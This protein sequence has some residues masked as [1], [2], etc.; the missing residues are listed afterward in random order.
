[1]MQ[2]RNNL[3]SIKK[4]NIR[5]TDKVARKDYY[6]Q[7][8]NSY[9]FIAPILILFGIFVVFPIVFN[10][11]VSFFKWSGVGE[12]KFSGL[13]NYIR[14]LIEDS[15]VRLVLRNAFLYIIISGSVNISVGLVVAYLLNMK[16]KFTT[17]YRVIIFMPAVIPG[18]VLAT[19]FGSILQADKGIVNVLL[20]KIGFEFTPNWFGDPKLVFFTI[21]II[22]CFIYMGYGMVIYLGGMQNISSE[23]IEAAKIDGAGTFRIF[24]N[25]V[26][27][28]LR[29]GHIIMITLTVTGAFRLFD[30]VWILTKG[31]PAGYSEVPA[32]FIYR[33]AMLEN[34]MGYAG[35]IGVMIFIISIFLIIFLQ[36]IFRKVWKY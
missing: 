30:L 19:I 24:F 28:L 22:S 7:K 34:Q 1:M 35:V 8:L 27:P 32:S 21:I 20:R 3:D 16:I 29:S 5:A 6:G 12:L 2:L 18:V 11:V 13:A 4:K 9:L 25:I 33:A 23:I 14:F 10:I 31:G 15:R 26:V 17:I 36:F